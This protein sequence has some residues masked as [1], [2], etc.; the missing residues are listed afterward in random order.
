MS[1][2][3]RLDT[4]IIGAGMSGLAAGIRSAHFGQRVQILE[5]H[6]L[7]GGLNSFYKLAGRRFDVGLHA[8]TNFADPRDPG[9]K[10]LPLAKVLRQLRLRYEDLQLGEQTE[11][12]IDFPGVRLRFSNDFDLMCTEIAEKFPS[13]IDG[14]RSFVSDFADYP[15]LRTDPPGGSARARLARYIDDPLLVDMLLLPVCYY[16]S[17]TERDLEWNTFLIMFKSIFEEGLARPEGGVRRILDLLRRRFQELGGE[18]RMR[19]GVERIL[20]DSSGHAVGVRL[21]D[22]SEVHA[23]CILS[24]AGFVE[25]MRL[26]GERHADAHV[27]GEHFGNITCVESVSVLDR[28][29]SAL[30]HDETIVFFNTEES[31]FFQRPEAPVDYRSGVIC[32]TDNYAA[33]VPPKEGF[34]RLTV[35]ANYD[36]WNALGDDEYHAL[37][38]RVW[39]EGHDVVASLGFDVRDH[40]VFKD[41]FTPRT[42]ERF[43]GHVNGALYGSPVKS[44]QGATP[45]PGLYLC[46][47][48]QGLVGVVGAL[49]SGI[50]MAN[51]HALVN[52]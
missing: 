48:D 33:R 4:L 24:S 22:G 28:T 43:T 46:G 41:V 12:A 21:E 26:C 19:T 17:P 47:T 31:M 20:L 45:V 18:L 5:K 16:G 14:F 23:R 3:E 39:Q 2:S 34:F 25:T 11:S 27:A 7:W 51:R 10:R 8:L 13:E 1:A 30:G 38:A 15:N 6:Y 52:V 35:L 50:S 37:K 36:A 32:C 29:C 9:A 40:T 49:L 44:L 42:I